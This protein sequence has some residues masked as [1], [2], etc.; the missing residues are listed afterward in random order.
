[1]AFYCLPLAG[2][3]MRLSNAVVHG[4]IPVIVQASLCLFTVSVLGEGTTSSTAN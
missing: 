3:G 2:F 1:M 4:C